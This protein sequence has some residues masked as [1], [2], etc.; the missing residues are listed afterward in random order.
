ME[1]ERLM[2]L[3]MIGLRGQ[4]TGFSIRGR[5]RAM[6]FISLYFDIYLILRVL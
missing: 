3:E 2:E 6:Y 5:C 1:E 4:N